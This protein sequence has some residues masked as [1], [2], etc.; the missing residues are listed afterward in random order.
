MVVANPDGTSTF[1][2]EAFTVESDGSPLVATD[3]IGFDK[4]R[5]GKPQGYFLQ[6]TN[7]GSLDSAP[8]LVSLVVPSAVASN[9]MAGSDLFAAGITSNP[10]F[11][12]PSTNTVNMSFLLFAAPAVPAGAS[13]LAPVQ[14][15][16]PLGSQAPSF[17]LTAGWQQDLTDL[18]VDD[19]LELEGIPFVPFPANGCA[20]CLDQYSAELQAHSD[21]L[22]AYNSHQTAKDNFN[23]RI[24]SIDFL[25]G[26]RG[27]YGVHVERGI[28]TAT[29]C[30]KT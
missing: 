15:T 9:Q 17:V 5:F 2:P 16:L 3:I 30:G 14:L 6:L 10:E 29:A 18:S 21:V 23:S 8:G 20:A 26:R 28:W 7:A 4:I 11:A 19:F 22:A 27:K 13:V 25:H 12:I 1:L 24:L